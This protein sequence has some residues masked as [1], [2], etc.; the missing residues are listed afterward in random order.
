MRTSVLIFLIGISFYWIRWILFTSLVVEL[1]FEKV[2]NYKIGGSVKKVAVIGGGIG[3]TS[4][5]YFLK[6]LMGENVVITLYEKRDR[7]GGRTASAY[8]RDGTRY[9][10]GGTSFI[11]ENHYVV[12]FAQKFNL[13]FAPKLDHLE[14]VV[15]WNDVKKAIVFQELDS[16]IVTHSSMLLKYNLQ[17]FE[18]KFRVRKLLNKF[19][20]IYSLQNNGYTFE[21]VKALVDKL[22]LSEYTGE[23]FEEYITTN[24]TMGDGFWRDFLVPILGVNYNQG[25]EISS[26]AALVSSTAIVSNFE[27]LEMGTDAISRSLADVTKMTQYLN[28]AVTRIEKLTTGRY[29]LTNKKC[30]EAKCSMEVEE[31]DSVVLATP[32]EL[33]KIDFVGLKFPKPCRAACRYVP[34]HV[35]FVVGHLNQTVFHLDPSDKFYSILTTEQDPERV[36]F[37][38]ALAG[39]TKSLPIYKIFSRRL[40]SPSFI[41]K[42]FVM[43]DSAANEFPE[44]HRHM[45]RAY[46]YLGPSNQT[47]WNSFKVDDGFYQVNAME[48]IISTIET[49]II[50]ARNIAQ[51]IKKP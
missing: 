23:T 3:G 21:S 12:H 4:C 26:F 30:H 36:F 43:N 40:I 19:L 14:K 7:L 17:I 28:S 37:K 49:E 42:Y 41:K 27:K 16:D 11:S 5:A 47:Q 39:M 9:D 15:I 13:S 44:M 1:K 35:T 20:K 45:F 8:T 24:V 31:Y 25:T 29:Q 10:V 51:M 2:E 50:A 18:A 33:S 46:P 34:V 22:E 32:D 38:I 48:S 6:E